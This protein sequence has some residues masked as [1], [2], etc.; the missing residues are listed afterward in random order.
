MIDNPDIWVKVGIRL[1]DLFAGFAGGVVNAFASKRSD[2]WSILGS[3]V[4]GGLM[5]N[6]L[7]ET[8]ASYLG[9]M[10]T[11][12]AGFVIGVAGMTIAQGI[13]EVSKSWRPFGSSNGKEKE[14]ERDSHA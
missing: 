14:R 11:G 7:S 1:Q 8:F 5:A 3:L 4:A 6:Y 13:I 2:P 12:V 10:K 9:G